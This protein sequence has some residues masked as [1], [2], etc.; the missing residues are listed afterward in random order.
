[1]RKQTIYILFLSTFA[2]SGCWLLFGERIDTSPPICQE[3]LHDGSVIYGKK[4]DTLTVDELLTLQKCG[5]AVHPKY[6]LS[7]DVAHR[8]EYPVPKILSRLNSDTNKEYQL[9]LIEDLS[10]LTE[11]DRHRDRMRADEAVIMDS[12]DRAISN[13]DKWSAVKKYAQAEREK[14]EAFFHEPKPVDTEIQL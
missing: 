7:F 13:M 5:L 12:V 10:K 8:E 1:M 14:L 6:A 9:M 11:S 3:A 2:F 4:L